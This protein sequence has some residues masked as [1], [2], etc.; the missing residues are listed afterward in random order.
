MINDQTLISRAEQYLRDN[1]AYQVFANDVDITQDVKS[2]A[3]ETTALD[4]E[5]MEPITGQA[6]L[7]L[8]GDH[9]ARFSNETNVKI[10]LKISDTEVLQVFTGYSDVQTQA[11]FS[12][13]RSE[14]TVKIF[15]YTNILKKKRIAKQT[16]Q[17]V[18][19][20]YHDN[21]GNSL[22]HI[23]L[24][25]VN[26]QNTIAVANNSKSYPLAVIEEGTLYDAVLKAC[27]SVGCVFDY[28]SG[29]FRL[30]QIAHD[31]YTPV[32]TLDRCERLTI[33]RLSQEKKNPVVYGYDITQTNQLV[34]TLTY[35]TSDSPQECFIPISAGGHWPADGKAVAEIE[36][37][38]IIKLDN[39][40]F[41]ITTASGGSVVA[42]DISVE[43][44]KIKF[45][46]KNIT[47]SDQTVIKCRISAD[48][49][50]ITKET[51]SG[52]T[53]NT[54]NPELKQ[55]WASNYFIDGTTSQTLAN[56]IAQRWKARSYKYTVDT[57][58]LPFLEIGDII[59]FQD[60]ASGTNSTC[61]I[62]ALKHYISPAGQ[63]STVQ[64]I[65]VE[66]VS[67]SVTSET[68]LNQTP[69]NINIVNAQASVSLQEVM[70]TISPTNTSGY[71]GQGWTTTPEPPTIK[72][73]R[74]RNNFITLEIEPQ[75][76][77]SNFERYE[78]QIS[79][80]NGGTWTNIAEQ[81]GQV[82]ISY[83]DNWQFIV[84]WNT[85]SGG[86]AIDTQV[87]IRVR[88]KTKA[89]LYSDWAY[90]DNITLQASL[91]A[92]TNNLGQVYCDS[93]IFD[94]YNYIAPSAFRLGGETSYMQFVN[95][96]L[97]LQ[98]AGINIANEQIQVGDTIIKSDEIQLNGTDA[99]KWL[100]VGKDEA[101]D[102]SS[103]VW[104]FIVKKEIAID[105]GHDVL[106]T[107]YENGQKVL[108]VA[109]PAN[110]QL[111]I[112]N[113]PS[114]IKILGTKK[115]KK[116]LTEYNYQLLEE[117]FLVFQPGVYVFK[118]YN[119][120]GLISYPP[121]S[122]IFTHTITNRTWTITN[123][124][125]RNNATEA[126]QAANPL[127]VGESL[128]MHWSGS[129][130]FG[131][132]DYFCIPIVWTDGASYEVDINGKSVGAV[133]WRG[134]YINSPL[135][136]EYFDNGSS[137]VRAGDTSNFR[138]WHSIPDDYSNLQK[139]FI[140]CKRGWLTLQG[141]HSHYAQIYISRAYTYQSLLN[142]RPLSAVTLQ[143]FHVKITRTM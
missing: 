96:V 31:T 29:F 119:P 91:S 105:C 56:R 95:N 34:Y 87:K 98:A 49:V 62:H 100:Y 12:D 108:Y 36:S 111:Q 33:D 138:V 4:D 85:D 113:F 114:G 28:T 8:T 50:K 123:E 128:E 7:V 134:L 41:A 60:Q 32:Y 125:F 27:H 51:R 63:R 67:T 54:S 112:F 81:T 24:S 26:L 103:D 118:G 55:E 117:F 89:N 25:Q 45:R 94:A 43:G 104:L 124:I 140:N 37:E 82:E 30:V 92:I 76:N 48:V 126:E 9:R 68:L 102:E 53:I 109:R 115:L 90:T 23:L 46:L 129:Q 5:K 127:E 75:A 35:K 3:I 58:Y 106:G 6:T 65:N 139:L 2:I 88:R 61:F 13:V 57:Y 39:P 101:N 78:Y 110:R 137:L 16:Y 142:L 10:F 44:K 19:F 72:S 40:T 22:L 15:D 71:S 21:Q 122:I 64:L 135:F 47:G 86:K 1:F 73:L 130:S 83:L 77:L 121:P 17:N 59:Q 38:D 107:F 132:G 143:E 70:A 79:K 120:L 42:E 141:R 74:T 93:V 84:P 116:D 131:T 52:E 99:Y 136:I 80:D 20:C 97:Q 133:W 69:L 66:A 11:N 14:T 18:V